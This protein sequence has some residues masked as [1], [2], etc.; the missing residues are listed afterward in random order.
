M[1]DLQPKDSA[2]IVA[3]VTY[4]SPLALFSTWSIAP[5]PKE[6]NHYAL[7]CAAMGVLMTGALGILTDNRNADRIAIEL[8]LATV[9]VG[10]LGVKSQA[11]RKGIN[12]AAS[13]LEAPLSFTKFLYDTITTEGGY[14]TPVRNN[15]GVC[16]I[17]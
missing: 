14:Y 2:W 11:V 10:C 5:N 13:V 4:I 8:P 16:N 15:D 12:I 17:L 1:K 7:G 6:A 3:S 9:A